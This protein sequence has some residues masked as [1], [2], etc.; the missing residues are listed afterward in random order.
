MW[1]A[2]AAL[3]TFVFAGMTTNAF[4]A[5][6]EGPEAAPKETTGAPAQ[7]LDGMVGKKL[8][9]IDGSTIALMPAEGG[10]AREIIG[11]NGAVQKTMFEFINEKLGTV[12]D[13]RNA[14]N[15]IGVFRT[16]GAGIEVQYADGSSETLA[17]NPSGG[18][19]IESISASSDSCIA[20][21]PEG[22]VFSLE[23][24]RVALAQFATKL[25][26]ADAGG[27][28]RSEGCFDL[29]ERRKRWHA[30]G[31]PQSLRL[32]RA[33]RLLPDERHGSIRLVP[34][35]HSIGKRCRQRI[36]LPRCG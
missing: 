29:P 2:R 19:T 26:L 32:Q 9:A 31:L 27:R 30:L 25:G 5:V 6:L 16:T 35:R 4:A 14:A 22:H 15:V 18:L 34:R 8:I 3:L 7:S 21:Y 36:W 20:W 11:S 12:S 24:R 33:V 17:T 1:S 28:G 23:E 10:L 13:A